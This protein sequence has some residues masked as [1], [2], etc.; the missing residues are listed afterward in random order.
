[1]APL[2]T[3]S[4]KAPELRSGDVLTR[5][6]FERRYEAMPDLK[7]AELIEGVVYMP[8]PV[9]HTYHGRPHAQLAGWISA[10][11]RATSGTEFAITSTFRID[12]DNE[13]QPDLML[14]RTGPDA[15]SRIDTDGY[16]EGAP[17]LLVEVAA[18]SVSYDLHQKKRIYRRC[19]VREYLVLRSEDAEVD[20]FVLRAGAYE[21]L[22]PDAAGVLRSEAFPGLWLGVPALLAGDDAGMVAV[23]RA[24]L[25]D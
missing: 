2:M 4:P 8:S 10:Y 23:L 6:E 25:A 1:M 18:S 20:W 21:R 7:R 15:G 16:I 12:L 24:G 3:A 17:E 11:V 9:R 14:R 19:G 22:A 5:D 13:V